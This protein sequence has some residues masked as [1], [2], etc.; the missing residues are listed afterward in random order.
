MVELLHHR[1]RQRAGASPPGRN[2]LLVLNL[3][4]AIKPRVTAEAL[5][6]AR[7]CSTMWV[8]SG[9]AFHHFSWNLST[10]GSPLSGLPAK[11]GCTLNSGQTFLG[12][13]R[14]AVPM[15]H[16]AELHRAI[17]AATAGAGRGGA[18]NLAS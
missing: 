12:G 7:L 14:V 10:T 8:S 3:A 4:S 11:R 9:G 17:G 13:R 5:N 18:P 15:V 6:S 1:V 16:L 2:N